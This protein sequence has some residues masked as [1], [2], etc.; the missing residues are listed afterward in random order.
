MGGGGMWDE[1]PEEVVQD[2]GAATKTA[3]EGPR[4]TNG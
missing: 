1:V 4:L 2:N 3:T